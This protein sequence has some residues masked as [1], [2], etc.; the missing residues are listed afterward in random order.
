MLP[1]K[2]KEDDKVDDYREI[3]KREKSKRT[4]SDVKGPKNEKMALNC[5]GNANLNFE[6]LITEFLLFKVTTK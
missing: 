3:I 2:S 6:P 4:H 5:I 1:N